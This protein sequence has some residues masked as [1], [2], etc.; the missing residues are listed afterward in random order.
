MRFGQSIIADYREYQVP[1]KGKLMKLGDMAEKVIQEVNPYIKNDLYK[2]HFMNTRTGE[3]N[4]EHP[5]QRKSATYY[6]LT[7]HHIPAFGVETSKFLPSVDLKV[8]Y[9]NLVINAFMRLFDIIPH[10]P[11]YALEKPKLDYLVISINEQIPVVIK[12]NQVLELGRGD[13]INISHI[14]ANYERGLSLDILGYGD[15]NDYRQNFEIFR[16]TNILVRKD[17][18]KFADIPVKIVS[19]RLVSHHRPGLKEVDYL[20]VE[21][22]G[23]RLLLADREELSLTRGEKFKIVDVIPRG[24]PNITVNFKG[25]V[26]DKVNN[27]GEDRGY[28]ID[29]SKDLMKRYS[30][31]NKG[32]LYQIVISRWS[33]KNTLARIF[34][35]IVPP[36]PF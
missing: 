3:V 31:H 8:Q 28:L 6:A 32:E 34:V 27:T 12:Q 17:N 11:S 15:L 22:K 4:S 18:H 14:E 35:K 36:K 1:G 30:L 7:R 23:L 20:I 9:H 24:L 33:E 21:A 10:S 2:F 13:R 26:G 29:T 5:E 16:N 25:F 19:D